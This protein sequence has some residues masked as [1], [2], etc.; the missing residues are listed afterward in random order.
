MASSSNKTLAIVESNADDRLLLQKAWQSVGLARLYLLVD[1]EDLIDF[2]YH[3]GKY[4]NSVALPQP[5]LLILTL[6]LPQTIGEE[7]LR[8]IKADQNLRTIPVI[9]LGTA[10]TEADINRSYALGACSFLS[11][12]DTYEG[13]VELMQMIDR[14][15]FQTV[16]LPH[17]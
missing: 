8:T 5:D 1:G 11:K 12:P 10:N 4:A 6:Q 2:L 13:L 7:V 15:W 14:Y 9:V 3:Q 16:L 17:C